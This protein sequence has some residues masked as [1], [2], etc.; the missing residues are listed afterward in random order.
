MYVCVD[1]TK[2]KPN[3]Y[4]HVN[5]VNIE[6]IYVMFFYVEIKYAYLLFMISRCSHSCSCLHRTNLCS[7]YEAATAEIFPPS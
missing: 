4:I 6:K 3:Y 2:A 1:N 5:L 7:L